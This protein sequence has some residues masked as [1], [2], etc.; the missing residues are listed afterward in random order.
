MESE[1]D[2]RELL[3]GIKVV[4]QERQLDE[5]TAYTALEEALALVLKRYR[6]SDEWE[7]RV[8]VDRKTADI[9]AFRRWRVLDE[10]EPMASA[11][12][13]IMLDLARERDPGLNPGDFWEEPVSP[14]D[15]AQRMNAQMAR[16]LIPQRL[17][18]AERTR[19]LN[20]FLGRGDELINGTVRKVDQSTY[21]AIIEASH[22]LEC[23]LRREDQVP[24]EN[25][26]PGDR[27]RAIIKEINS[28]GRVPVLCVTR[29]N[30]EFLRKLFEREVP[31]IESGVLEIVN[32]VREAGYR[33]KVA[34]RSNDPKVDPVGTCVGI[35][36]SR[37]QAVTNEIN[38][39][40]IDI[41]EWHE[42]EAEFVVKALA[43]AK[44]LKIAI[45]DDGEMIAFVREED[46]PLAIGRNGVNVRLASELTGRRLRVCTEEGRSAEQ[47]EE[48]ERTTKMFMERLDIDES[49]AA[50]LYD[51]GFDSIED[52][53]LTD[54]REMAEIEALGDLVDELQRRANQVLEE[55]ERR[56][57]EK[58]RNAD[59]RLVAL[60]DMDDQLL[61]ILLREDITTLDD[62][63]EL[64]T[65]EL[66]EISGLGD[67]DRINRLIMAARAP[68]LENDG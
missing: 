47:E 42:S 66:K 21:D 67:E 27:V 35:R 41:V 17:R 13:E 68:M 57:E 33:A 52:V 14:E 24:R 58:R 53:A 63:G 38:G 22:G 6:R 26:R 55:E 1:I 12:Y 64:A 48:K 29:A 4:C 18:D 49:V 59:P 3:Q 34:V 65:D 45:E 62:L 19:N 8:H 50:I 2:A 44:I 56:L 7:Y 5:E 61:R 16:Q 20:E 9:T 23:V 43:P 60:E 54:A 25:L 51:E 32:A 39:E 37:V 40:R 11:A 15:L 31:E 30:I 10:E 36:G 28:E 46:I